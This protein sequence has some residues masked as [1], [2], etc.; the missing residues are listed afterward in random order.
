MRRLL[1]LIPIAAVS[2]V[3]AIPAFAATRSVKVG[4]DY[5]VRDRGV[6]TV[7]VK[8]GDTVRWRFAGKAPHNVTVKSGPARFGSK[9]MTRGSYAKK[10]TRRGLYTIYCTIHGAGDQSMKLRVR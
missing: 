7:T 2:A 8:K 1:I 10:L 5:F 4:D 6:P 9:T 3:P